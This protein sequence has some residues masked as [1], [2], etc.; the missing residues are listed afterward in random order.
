MPDAEGRIRPVSIPD[1]PW[2]KTSPPECSF[3]QCPYPTACQ[4]GCRYPETSD[5]YDDG[6]TPT[7]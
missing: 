3:D 4:D 6:T 1:V 2:H 7:P 5:E